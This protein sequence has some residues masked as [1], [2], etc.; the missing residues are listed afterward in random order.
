MI[1]S[2]D[3]SPYDLTKMFLE[4][5]WIMSVLSLED[6]SLDPGMKMFHLARRNPSRTEQLSSTSDPTGATTCLGPGSTTNTE[7]KH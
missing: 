1:S 6:S 7:M 4:L 5:S 3:D 2:D